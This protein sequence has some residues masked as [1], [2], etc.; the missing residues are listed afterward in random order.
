MPFKEGIR[1]S[2]S[3]A[4][5]DEVRSKLEVIFSRYN[6]M[7]KLS[8]FICNKS[9]YELKGKYN[10]LFMLTNNVDK[11]RLLEFLSGLLSKGLHPYSIGIP[12]IIYD[13]SEILPTLAF[14]RYLAEICENKLVIFNY[15]LIYKIIY[16]KPIYINYAYNY[17]DVIIVDKMNNFIAYAKV[18]SKKR[19]V[20]EVIPVKDI[21]WYLR[22][23][24]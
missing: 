16:K 7:N 4:R 14:G 3:E 9:F 8:E 13:M 17:K 20:H 18:K 10:Q 23:G 5:I 24:G 22:R 19:G 12:I 11:D 15:N 2:F 21:G 1:M 6:C